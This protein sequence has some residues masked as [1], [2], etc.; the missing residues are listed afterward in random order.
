MDSSEV[1]LD[2]GIKAAAA[3]KH[4][5]AV[6]LFKRVVELEPRNEPAWLWLAAL[7][8]S[9][10]ERIACFENVLRINPEN[11][12][13][14]EQLGRLIEKGGAMP[15]VSEPAVEHEAKVAPSQPAGEDQGE[16]D[17]GPVECPNCGTH[18]RPEAEFCRQCGAHLL[19]PQKVQGEV[20]VMEATPTAVQSAVH[21]GAQEPVTTTERA[22]ERRSHGLKHLGAPLAA[23][24]ATLAVFQRLSGLEYVGGYGFRTPI[25]TAIFDPKAVGVLGVDLSTHI[26]LECALLFLAVFSASWLGL[27]VV[28][29]IIDWARGRK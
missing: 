29:S 1:L 9:D 25:L 26:M 20:A 10:E 16:A 17:D 23:F 4:G 24:I 15:L 2:E 12:G 22:V 14:R 5:E 3:N 18:N 8:D 6:A 21:P 27:F 7:A 11:Q 19:K 28:F 13:A